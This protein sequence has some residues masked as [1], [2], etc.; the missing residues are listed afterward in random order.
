MVQSPKVLTA[1][2]FELIEGL[3]LP[4][5]NG[6]DRQSYLYREDT[7]E[8]YTFRSWYITRRFEVGLMLK[9]AS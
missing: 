3:I 2:N 6:W 1:R 9:L 5:K 4:Y 7:T 8:L